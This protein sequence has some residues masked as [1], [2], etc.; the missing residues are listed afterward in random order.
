MP[1]YNRQKVLEKVKEILKKRG[2]VTTGILMKELG[3]GRETA[4]RILRQ[5]EEM[6]SLKRLKLQ[7]GEI[8]NINAWIKTPDE[9]FK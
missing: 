7:E 1:R 8:Y 9:E 6:G 5:L 3:C 2:V 4:G